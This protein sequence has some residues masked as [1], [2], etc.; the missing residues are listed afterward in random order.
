M[1]RIN[2]DYPRLKRFPGFAPALWLMM[3]HFIVTACATENNK[4]PLTMVQVKAGTLTMGAEPG[5][6]CLAAGKEYAGP[7]WDEA[8]RHQV[9][10]TKPFRIS[11]CKITNAEFEQFRPDH[12][13]LYSGT[14]K[15]PSLKD[16]DPVVMVSWYDAVAYCEWLSREK[17][18]PCR[19]P[20]EAEWEYAARH[21]GELDLQGMQDTILE[22]CHDWWDP[23]PDHLIEDP[24]GPSEGM[25]RVLRGGR[26]SNR[27]GNV[28]AARRALYGFR[29]VQV[30]LPEVESPSPTRSNPISLDIK[31]ARKIWGQPEDPALPHFE[32]GMEYITGPTD[33]SRLPYWGRHHVPSLTWCENGDMLVTA[34]TAPWDGSDQ[35]AI[36]ISRLQE[37]RQEWDPPVRFFIAP[38]HNVTSSMLYHASDGALHHYNGISEP[39][40]NRGFS[41][42]RRTSTDNGLTWSRP[43]IVHPYPSELASM[44]TYSGVP[45]LWPHMD[46]VKLD[47]GTWVMPSDVGG[48]HDRGTVLFE[49]R[50]QGESWTERTRFGWH[51]EGFAKKGRKAGWIAGI[52]ACFVVLGDGR[53]LALGRTN[54]IDGKSPFSISADSGRTWT[55][56]PSPFSPI[57]YGQRSVLRRLNEGPILLISFTDSGNLETKKGLESSDASGKSQRIYGLFSAL[58]LD[59][60][61]TWPVI[62]PIPIDPGNPLRTENWGYL[63]TVQTPDGMIHLVSSRRY[64]R[65]NLAWLKSPLPTVDH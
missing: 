23:Y 13:H 48:G 7:H 22:W 36:L 29:I 38:D 12:R 5:P 32:G 43:Q 30:D 47:D 18:E 45:R 59:E 50:S 16:S 58:S 3:A 8:P 57:S 6:G 37:G 63:S 34:F 21:A 35:M 54:N 28:P 61:N 26:P 60:G 2:P 65:F 41:M 52:H 55:Y 11:R 17:G 51:P 10:I 25:V 46:M 20:T 40:R 19:L 15:N 44:E 62:K 33:P 1:T 42:I 4:D 14:Y 56:R 49:S 31:Q 27:A 64:Y 9:R 53:Y 24:Q 39:G